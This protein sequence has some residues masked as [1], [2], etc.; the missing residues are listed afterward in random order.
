MGLSYVPQAQ[1]TL[2]NVNK[3]NNIRNMYTKAPVWVKKLYKGRSG[4]YEPTHDRVVSVITKLINALGNCRC[5]LKAV[6]YIEWNDDQNKSKKHW[7]TKHCKS[8]VER[9]E[10]TG[11]D[12]VGG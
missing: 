9:I 7:F 2:D 3:E 10:R 11:T 8:C 1:A 4:F 6:T 5:G 12:V